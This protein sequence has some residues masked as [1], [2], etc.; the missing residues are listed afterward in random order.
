M[1]TS[2]AVAVKKPTSGNIVSIQDAL[3]AQVAALATRVAAPTGST[4]RV[5]QDK[6]FMLPDGTKTPGPLQLVVVEF[7]SKNMF[8]EGAYDPKNISPPACF[9]IGND[10]KNMAPSKNAPTPQASSCAS[11]PM[12][13]FGSAGTGKACKEMRSMAV[14]PPDADA[15]T[16][17]WLLNTSPTANKGFDAFVATTARVFEMP[18]V[19]VVVTVGFDPKETYAKLVFS[20]P[21]PNTN[22]MAHFPRQEEARAMLSGEPD[23]SGF[24]KKP[25]AKAGRR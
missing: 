13:A 19:G 7:T 23:V 12:A 22:I 8:Y 24:Q 21:Q 25:P 18:P 9:A 11:C 3:K 20:D 10:V 1:A 17:L 14:L 2:K 5:T 16:P 15:D 6:Q 4:I